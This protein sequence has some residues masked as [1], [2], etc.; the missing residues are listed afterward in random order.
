MLDTLLDNG[1]YV[2]LPRHAAHL[3]D[4]ANR[5]SRFCDS[6]E[7]THHVEQAYVVNDLGFLFVNDVT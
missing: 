3:N 1:L 2:V 7:V 6:C 5:S 4:S